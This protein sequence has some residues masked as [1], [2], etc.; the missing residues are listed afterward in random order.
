MSNESADKK[1]HVLA[2]RYEI[3][4]EIGRGGFGMVYKARQLNMN[5]E[6]AIK[7]LPPQFMSVADVV[8][9]FKREA[10]LTSQLKHPN[11]ITI[12]DYGQA[13]DLLFIVM[14]LLDGEDLA[15]VLKRERCLDTE[16][17]MHIARQT[18]KSLAE[19]HEHGIVHR[20][21]KPEN[22]FLTRVGDD[23]DYVKILDFG[24]AKLAQPSTDVAEGRRL[25]VTGS[26]VGTPVYM[27]PEQ[28]A[29]EEVDHQ[30]DLYALGIIIYE[31]ACGKPP[32]ADKNPVKTMRAHLFSEVPPFPED[33]PLAGSHIERVVMQA[34]QKDKPLRFQS[35]REFLTAL[36]TPTPE[37]SGLPVSFFSAPRANEL[38]KTYD[39]EPPTV[40]LYDHEDELDAPSFHEQNTAAFDRIRR[41]IDMSTGEH[42]VAPIT[43]PERDS[44]PFG[45]VLPTQAPSHKGRE[46]VRESALLERP[47]ELSNGLEHLSN[48]GPGAAPRRAEHVDISTSFFPN[49]ITPLPSGG[50][51]QS[52]GL[53]SVSSILTVVE[54]P[55]AD[56][57][58]FVLTQPK[59]Q[60]S[61]GEPVSAVLPPTPHAPSRQS[62]QF[63]RPAVSTSSQLTSL[64]QDAPKRQKIDEDGLEVGAPPAAAVTPT[65]SSDDWHWDPTHSHE[66]A[67][68]VESGAY[69]QLQHKQKQ[70][71]AKTRSLIGLALILILF[72]GGVAAVLIGAGVIEL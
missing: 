19:A 66:L 62:D 16:R 35:A 37:I 6:V 27:S 1:G 54:P 10:Q 64:P 14:E 5:R 53:T 29:G 3:I 50:F 31:M 15:D 51:Q 39:K 45:A 42:E 24:I 4:D 9:R 60:P 56:E 25:T 55:P 7:V 34:L 59:A 13:D 57:E 38:T 22:I 11:T 47:R 72:C 63:T 69:P 52:S 20:D 40:E 67:R 12:H 65:A 46:R 48:I 68:D 58:I 30:T 33:S 44:I 28:A 70:K 71:K 41:N 21:L 2:G 43:N 36:E 49:D 26:T 32:F 23:T 18:L 17:I 61:L 8:E